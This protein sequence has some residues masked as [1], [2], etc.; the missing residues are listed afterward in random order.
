MRILITGDGGFIG[1]H[2]KQYFHNHGKHYIH[3][4][5]IK[6]GQDCRD[7]FKLNKY[8][9]KFDLVVHC[10][11]IIGGRQMIEH[12]PLKVATDLAI[13]SD[14]FNWAVRTKQPRIIYFSSCAAYPIE[15][16]NHIEEIRE[17][18][19]P[20]PV[21]RLG[22]YSREDMIDLHHIKTPDMS[23]GWSKLTG[24]F[25]A[26]FAQAEG[27]KVH[28]FR[29]F[30]GY[31]NDQDLTYPFPSLI[32]RAKKR[33]NP[34]TIWG[35]GNQVRDWIHV[36]DIVEAIIIAI[37]NDIFGPVNLGTGI[38]TSFL[39]FADKLFKQI[40]GYNPEI[41]CDETKPE[42]PLFRCAD[43]TKMKEFYVPKVTL[44]EGIRRALFNV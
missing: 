42:G 29:P 39:N 5:D 13:D 41:Y 3:C 21:A 28:I 20:E 11:A 2:F 10:A 17:I 19:N 40:P 9:I 12:E 4:C 1:R 31:G 44:E 16:Q 30:S 7:L 25:L 24:E 27:V 35:S 33:E 14:M 32:A 36:D 38:P 18:G 6:N 26:Q 43:I 8:D 15:I 23:Y 34:F 22:I 37:Y